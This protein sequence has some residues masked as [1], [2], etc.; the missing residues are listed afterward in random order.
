M[1]TPQQAAFD[2]L[3]Q[4]L[5]SAPVLVTPDVSSTAT[6]TLYTDASGFGLGAVLLQDNGAGLQPVSYLARKLNKH[7]CNYPVH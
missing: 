7:E 6:F 4:A 3:K 2:S 5:T 1:G